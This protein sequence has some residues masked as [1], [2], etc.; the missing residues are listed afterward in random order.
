MYV[1]I[2]YKVPGKP[3]E[4]FIALGNAGDHERAWIE[5]LARSITTGIRHGVPARVYIDQLR[6]ITCQPVIDGSGSFIKSPA[7]GLAKVLAEF[8]KVE[9]GKKSKTE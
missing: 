6:G 7:D 8:C 2:A 3:F 4:I 5:A 9:A 1:T